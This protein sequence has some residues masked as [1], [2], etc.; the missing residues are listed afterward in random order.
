MAVVDVSSNNLDRNDMEAGYGGVNIGSGGGGAVEPDFFYEG[1]Q[2]WGRKVGNANHR[3]LSVGIT[4]VDMTVAAN[5]VLMLKSLVTNFSAINNASE[6]Y[7]VFVGDGAAGS[8]CYQ[9][10]IA[11][12]GTLLDAVGG[13]PAFVY[14]VKGGWLIVPIDPNVTAW[15]DLEI[16]TP[17]TLTAIDEV[18]VASGFGSTSK[19]INI[20]IDA[21]DFSEGLWLVGGTSSDPDGIWQ[22]FVDYDEGEGGSGDSPRADRVGH[23]ATLDGVLYVFGQFTIGETDAGTDTDTIFQDSLQTIVFPGGRVGSGWNSVE[24]E[25]AQATTDVDM[26]NITFIGRGRDNLKHFFDSS[27]DQVDGTDDEIDITA[28]GFKTGDEVVYSAEGGTTIS[29]LTSGNAYYVRAV[30]ADAIS[31][32]A[33]SGIWRNAAYNDTSQIVLTAA[34]TGESHSLTLQPDTRPDFNARGTS[35]ALD[36]IACQFVRC[37][38][39]LGTAA[40]T[41]TDCVFVVCRR[42]DLAGAALTGCSIA[43]FILAEGIAAVLSTDLAGISD[44]SF[45]RTPGNDQLGHGIEIDTLGTYSFVGNLF[46][47]YG[48]DKAS[49][50]TITGVDESTEIITTDD[51]HGF[52]DGDA[53]FYGKEGGSDAVGLT[54]GD[55]YYVNEIS[56]TTL[57]LHVTRADAE[58]DAN[59]VDL[60]DGGGG[61][62]HFLY[63]AHAGILNSSGGLVTINV[64]STG[65]ASVSIRNTPGST[66]VVQS[67][68]TLQVTVQDAA[69][70]AV[71]YATVRIENSTTG[72]LITEGVANDLGVFTNSSFNYVSDVGVNVIVRKTSPGDTRYNP[73]TAPATIESTGLSLTVSMIVDSAAGLLPA[74]GVMRTGARSED[75]AGNAIQTLNIDVPNVGTS[76][77]LLVGMMYWDAVTGLVD[78][79]LTYDG[80]AM[81]NVSGASTSVNEAAGEFHEIAWY[82]ID[83]PDADEGIKQVVATW[84]GNVAIKGMCF[85]ILDDVV[86]GAVDDAASQTGTQVTSNPSVSLNN[87]AQ[88]AWSLVFGMVDDTDSPSATGVATVKRSDLVVDGLKSMAVLCAE[89]LTT[90][91]HSLG[92]DYGGNSKTWVFGGVSVLKN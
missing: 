13:D 90:G 89:R 68:V 79:S 7:S 15:R 81:T 50:E 4:A 2:S 84:S 17:P 40:V 35:G 76:R 45:T 39:F 83:L 51:P 41:F 16:G 20:M 38:G 75:E 80:D 8:D 11:D 71:P 86:T 42:I 33:G 21:L 58:A 78:T 88:P 63:S 61:E 36:Y 14:P 52:V 87:T 85:A 65:D 77:K 12:D 48:P 70:V 53:V 91:A 18:G 92:V 69:A 57:S 1:I 37:G 22:D 82:F 30:T 10:V 46:T 44:C 5:L 74:V 56:A 34:G 29:G 72:A 28:H 62:T 73:V 66:T 47:S 32:H 19:E 27:A 55:R 64:D 25:L 23:V 24:V 54:D 26:T 6:G 9:Y 43:D 67:T 60:T 59:R 31:L 3:G 49:F